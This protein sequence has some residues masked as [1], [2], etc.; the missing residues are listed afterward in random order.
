M[1]NKISNS[2]TTLREKFHHVAVIGGP[3]YGATLKIHGANGRLFV[4]ELNQWFWSPQS[5]LPS[6]ILTDQELE[7]LISPIDVCRTLLLS[8]E[9]T[10]I[11]LFHQMDCVCA[12][13]QKNRSARKEPGSSQSDMI[14]SELFRLQVLSA[15]P[16][17][18]SVM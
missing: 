6:C 18:T 7:N 8:A 16:R 1:A 12:Y 3:Q 4:S 9:D 17:S 11:Q 2:F 14:I 5:G 10:M 15:A 13:V